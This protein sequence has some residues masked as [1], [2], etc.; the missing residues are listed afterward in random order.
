MANKFD[1]TN[2][3]QILLRIKLSLGSTNTSQIQCF[4]THSPHNSDSRTQPTK[5]QNYAKP[6]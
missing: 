5:I 6:I 3:P 1:L 2:L 4:E